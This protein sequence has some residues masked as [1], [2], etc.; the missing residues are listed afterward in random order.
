M[1]AATTRH[2][3]GRRRGLHQPASH[4]RT[5]PRRPASRR[6]RRPARPRTGPIE[7]TFEQRHL[8]P[9]A[10]H[11]SRCRRRADRPRHRPPTGPA[12]CTC[13]RTPEQEIAFEAGT[14]DARADDR[15]ARRG[16]GR[17][18]RPRA[19]RRPARS[20]LTWCWSPGRLGRTPPTD[21]RG[22]GPADPPSSWRSPV[23]VAAA[24]RVLHRA[25]RS[26]GA[27]P[28][29]TPPP[30]GRPAPAVAA[31]RLTSPAC[32]AARCASS[33]CSCC[34]YA[35]AAAVLGRTPDQPVLRRLLRAALGRHRAAR[36]CC[37][38]PV[39]KA[40]SPMRT[41]NALFAR[42]SGSDPEAR[43]VRL[44]RAA[45]LLAGGAR[46]SSPSSGWSWST[47]TR[48]SSARCGCGARST[49]R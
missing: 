44:P 48:P 15:P 39:W 34:L 2:H 5:R 19:D 13:T 14:T 12:S 17:V 45:G 7:I 28:G 47:R 27:P 10:A 30:P 49:S 43:H 20:P 16:R 4:P 8:R 32:G 31:S 36:R 21:R 22:Q 35:G 29:T 25:G 38:G 40:I 42:L 9:P 6:A 26:P 1:P 41:I 46:A 24:G 18:P 33:A 3:P 23:R 37:F 11:G